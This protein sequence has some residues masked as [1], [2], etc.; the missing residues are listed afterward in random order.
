LTVGARVA[1]A[2]ARWSAPRLG[3]VA[4]VVGAVQFVAGMAIAQLG[5]TTPYSLRDNFISDLGAVNCGYIGTPLRYVCSPWHAVFDLSA[6]LLGLLF[7]V[8]AVLV[9]SALPR[10]RLTSIGVAM[11]VLAGLGSIGVGL[12]PEDVNLPVHSFSALI[13]FLVGNSALFVLGAAIYTDASWRRLGLLSGFLGLVGLGALVAFASGHWGALGVG[14]TERLTIAP[15]LLWGALAGLR[16]LVKPPAT[17][18][19]TSPRPIVRPST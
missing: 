18:S 2:N 1:E 7:I 3:A 19:E 8:G 12:S 17:V 6:F 9:R 13:A 10:G 5:W 4:W 11:I 14:G 16:I 15:L